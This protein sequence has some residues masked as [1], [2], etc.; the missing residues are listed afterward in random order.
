MNSAQGHNRPPKPRLARAVRLPTGACALC[1]RVQ[2]LADGFCRACARERASLV[3]FCCTCGKMHRKSS[4]VGKLH[5]AEAEERHVRRL[6][7]E[8]GLR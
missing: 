3:Y 1:T 7:K 2:L 6:L 5:L 8:S 4:K